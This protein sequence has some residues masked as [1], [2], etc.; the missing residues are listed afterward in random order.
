MAL[1]LVDNGD[2]TFTVDI[3]GAG[4]APLTIGPSGS[5]IGVQLG[6]QVLSTVDSAGYSWST[7][8]ITGWGGSPASSLAL[9]QKL[10]A[11]GAWV[12]PRQLTPRVVTLSGQVWA[13]S[14]DGLRAAEDALN[15]ACSLDATVLAVSEGGMTRV[16]QVYRQDVVLFEWAHDAL[17]N[18]SVQIVAA[19]PRKYAPQ[20]ATSTA[21]PASSGGLT[22]PF[23]VPFTIASTVVSGQCSLTNP[24]NTTGPVTLR[25]DGPVTGPV[26]T[27]VSSG[28][29]LVFSSSLSLA[30][31][32]FLLIDM[33]DQTVLANGQ[34][35]R[36][37]FVTSRGWSGFDPSANTWSFAAT[38]GSGML[39]V[40]ATPAWL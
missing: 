22:V 12:G 28:L 15:A 7:G 5:R 39:T 19:D 29:Q 33:E 8:T 30:A 36:N 1:S 25:I 32:E 27:H 18:W 23:T 35:S 6:S 16:A 21:L 34:S 2:G 14:P 3:S 9:T 26:V 31:G 10:R 24:G 38:S 40:T 13:G 17:A 11:P 4:G 20:L 37:G